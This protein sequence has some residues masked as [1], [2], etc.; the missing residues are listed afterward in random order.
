[1]RPAGQG[2]LERLFAF[3]FDNLV[4][5]ADRNT[6]NM[7]AG[8]HYKLWLID[9]TRAFQPVGELLSPDKVQLVRRR[10]WKRLLEVSGEDLADATREYLDPD[11]VAALKARREL[12]VGHIRALIEER[13][14]A[15]V[16]Y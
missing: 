6:G 10:A 13:G 7:L 4:C 9:H 16:L 8:E 15:A 1:M 3:A 2:L 11:Q 14:E 5:N 12:L